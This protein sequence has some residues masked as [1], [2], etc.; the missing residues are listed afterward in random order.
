[1]QKAPLHNRIRHVMI[2]QS[3]FITLTSDNITRQSGVL[4][5]L[6]STKK[7][8]DAH[9]VTGVYR[10][11]LILF[12]VWVGDDCRVSC[13]SVIIKRRGF[14]TFPVRESTS[15]GIAKG[16]KRLIHTLAP[17]SMPQGP[18]G[19]VVFIDLRLQSSQYGPLVV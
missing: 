11:S 19:S 7:V 5:G 6:Q 4:S 9:E 2:T 18:P 12:D 13:V 15:Q 16:V 10:I 14:V 8:T 17:P 3:A 1:M